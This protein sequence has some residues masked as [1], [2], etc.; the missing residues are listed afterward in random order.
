M[1]KY[2]FNVPIYFFLLSMFTIALIG[3]SHLKKSS[4][5]DLTDILAILNQP[6]EHAME[7]IK[8][9]E[10]DLTLNLPFQYKWNNTLTFDQKEYYP[11]LEFSDDSK[12][13]TLIQ[14][15]LEF[16]NSDLK[17]SLD[18]AKKL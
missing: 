15:G 13:A 6:K 12:N 17:K 9:D 3:C 7:M 8:I 14:Y 5:D 10:K 18:E 11:W 1:K 16:K 2:N 4:K